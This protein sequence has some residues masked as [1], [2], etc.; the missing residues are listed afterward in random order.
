MCFGA[1]K[2]KKKKYPLPFASQTFKLPP[3]CFAHWNFDSGALSV[4]VQIQAN[5]TDK[6]TV[7][8]SCRALSYLTCHVTIG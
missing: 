7:N 2:K 5:E 4:T 1:L 6:A 8:T 3:L